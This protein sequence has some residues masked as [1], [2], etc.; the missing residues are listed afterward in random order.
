MLLL[1]NQQSLPE[2]LVHHLVLARRARLAPLAFA[3]GV[4]REVDRSL[5][6][7]L[8]VAAV[9]ESVPVADLGLARGTLL[10]G[11]SFMDIPLVRF[12]LL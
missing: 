3:L 8:V 2:A 1:V 6:L 11:C 7:D 10:A 9:Q 5:V 12:H 4:A